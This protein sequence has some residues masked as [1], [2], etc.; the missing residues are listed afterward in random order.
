MTVKELR[1]KLA[2]L[3]NERK[4][5]FTKMT[6]GYK[7]EDVTAYEAKA[8]EIQ[9]VEYALTEAERI[10]LDGKLD[11]TARKD[12][13]DSGK[14]KLTDDVKKFIK[15]LQDAV[16]IGTTYTGLVP[17]SIA[18]DIVRLRESFGKLRPRCRKITLAA[19]YTIAIDAD[20]VVVEYIDEAGEVPEKNPS[21][22]TVSF[23]AYKLGAL[24]KVSEEFLSDISVD[25]LGWLVENMA[26]AFAKKEDIEIVV[27]T[28][29]ANKH[30]TGILTAVTANAVTAV[31]P[32][33]VTLDEVKQLIAALGDYKDG[34]ILIMSPATKLAIS[35]LKDSNKQYY[36]PIQNELKQI[37]GCDIVELGTVDNMAADKRSIIAAN[38]NYY[39]I[40]DRSGMK[41]TVLNELY[42]ANDQKGLKG[43]ERLDGNILTAGAFKVL[44]MGPAAQG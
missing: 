33:E 23:T 17:S 29:A 41:I 27:G 43:I 1:E 2:A 7:A 6:D 10:E 21:L 8:K 16:S 30:L 44:K 3:R 26:R 9:N 39:Q 24:V 32:T 35:L 37:Q 15:H 13:E 42:A 18:A 19:D 22:G 11:D 34:A 36:F 28:G 5:L 4:A 38:M 31:S 20:Q 40:V 12:L 25:V 14:N